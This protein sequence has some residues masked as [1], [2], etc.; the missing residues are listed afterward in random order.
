MMK[1]IAA[2]WKVQENQVE[3]KLKLLANADDI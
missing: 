2:A 3:L 1:G